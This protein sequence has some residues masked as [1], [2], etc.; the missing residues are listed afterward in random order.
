MK[1]A[2]LVVILVSRS[3]SLQSTDS[4]SADYESLYDDL[5][6]EYAAGLKRATE[7]MSTETEITPETV[8]YE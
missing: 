5:V 4:D 3:C 2:L 1:V 7:E 8:I 6:A